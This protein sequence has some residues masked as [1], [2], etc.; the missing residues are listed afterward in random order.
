M[1]NPFTFTAAGVVRIKLR[2][3]TWRLLVDA[4]T[5]LRTA[6]DDLTAEVTKVADRIGTTDTVP[7][8]EVQ[9][10]ADDVATQTGR[11]V[12]ILNPPQAGTESI[13]TEARHK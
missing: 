11:L 3:K 4:L 12:D 10:A 1:R 8:G 5:N 7:A 9:R 6:I 13:S 2:G